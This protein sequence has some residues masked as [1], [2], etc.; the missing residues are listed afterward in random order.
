MLLLLPRAF[1]QGAAS[2]PAK[3]ET[4]DATPAAFEV[5]SVKPDVRS[6]A[7]G[8][9]GWR[10]IV[11]PDPGQVEHLLDIAIDGLRARP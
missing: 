7:G 6:K 4:K 2:S 9:A 8:L 10:E 3:G 11:T 5:A 1:G